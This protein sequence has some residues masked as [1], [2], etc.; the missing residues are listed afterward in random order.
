[1][2]AYDDFCLCNDCM[3]DITPDR[4]PAHECVVCKQVDCVCHRTRVDWKNYNYQ[5]TPS[6][7]KEELIEKFRAAHRNT[8]RAISDGIMRFEGELAV[9]E[10]GFQANPLYPG[11]YSNYEE[12][13]ITVVMDD[14]G[15]DVVAMTVCPQRSEDE[16]E[17]DGLDEPVFVM[18][19]P[20][21]DDDDADDSTDIHVDVGGSD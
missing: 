16:E 9:V 6:L 17:F 18:A 11:A 13:E 15:R 4:D 8:E 19:G 21:D 2:H 20:D 14:T 10:P 12:G 3:A 1:M 7:S 5:Y